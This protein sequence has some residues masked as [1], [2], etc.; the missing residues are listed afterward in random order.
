MFRHPSLAYP[1]DTLQA[2]K[3]VSVRSHRGNVN[4]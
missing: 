3:F 4:R 2:F 1:S